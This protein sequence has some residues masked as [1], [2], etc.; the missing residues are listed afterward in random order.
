MPDQPCPHCH[1]RLVIDCLNAAG[2][3]SFV[4]DVRQNDYEQCWL[5]DRDGALAFSS[6]GHGLPDLHPRPCRAIWWRSLLVVSR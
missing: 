4:W 3:A 6:R 1:G 2:V 5:V